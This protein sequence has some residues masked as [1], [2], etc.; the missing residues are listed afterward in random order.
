MRDAQVLGA[1]LN[2]GC[3][4]TADDCRDDTGVDQHFDAL[5]IQRVEC[6]E[7]AAVF[8]EIQPAIGQ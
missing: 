7:L 4:T 5:T 1:A 8:K 6:L 3:F 2:D